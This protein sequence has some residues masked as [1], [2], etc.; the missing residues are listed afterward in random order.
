MKKRVAG[1]K[2]NPAVKRSALDR[3]ESQYSEF[4]KNVTKLSEDEFTTRVVL[5]LFRALGFG[6]VEDHGGRSEGGRDF[7]C[8][9]KDRVDRTLLA[10]RPAH[11]K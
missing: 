8:W 2:K 10:A 5:P 3:V 11:T 6:H 1:S 7:I 9:G 4:L